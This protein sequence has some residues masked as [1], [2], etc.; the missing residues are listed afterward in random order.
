M[1]SVNIAN[2]SIAIPEKNT[3]LGLV[4]VPQNDKAIEE[5]HVYVSSGWY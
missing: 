4:V 3:L 2:G 1:F 5:G